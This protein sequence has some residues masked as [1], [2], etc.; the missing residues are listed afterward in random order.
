MLLSLLQTKSA[1][2]TTTIKNLKYQKH[3]LPNFEAQCTKN[4]D[5]HYLIR[6]I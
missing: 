5:I 3:K 4:K 1:D 6:T 2:F